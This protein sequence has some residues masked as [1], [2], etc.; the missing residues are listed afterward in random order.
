MHACTTY[1]NRYIIYR[2]ACTY[3]NAYV[4]ERERERHQ[5]Q[6][7]ARR[8]AQREGEGREGD[9]INIIL[10][11]AT[12]HYTTLSYTILYYTIH[13]YIYIYIHNVYTYIYIYIDARRAPRRG[14]LE[15]GGRASAWVIIM[16]MIIRIIDYD[17][18]NN[19]SNNNINNNN[20]NNNNNNGGRASASAG[21]GRARRRS[22]RA[23][24]RECFKTKK[25]KCLN[26]IF[27]LRMSKRQKTNM[28]RKTS[29]KTL[30]YVFRETTAN[31]F[32]M[33]HVYMWRS[34]KSQ[35]SGRGARWLCEN[36]QRLRQNVC[37]QTNNSECLDVWA[38]GPL[39]RGFVGFEMLW[40]QTD[41][42]TGQL[43]QLFVPKTAERKKAV[44]RNGSA[45]MC[46][47]FGGITCLTPLA[48][49]GLVCF[50]RF[51]SCQGSQ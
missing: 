32:D 38:T 35:S 16:I 9:N 3:F 34:S 8:R 11:Y 44:R 20:S 4:C 12:L 41:Q 18:N 37:I 40:D 29:A 36:V 46:C 21:R 28:F 23:A 45:E 26:H 14:P 51:S 33:I 24:G 50:V 13:I 15:F 1:V 27:D 17:N 5:M 49:Y 47:M 48:W 19:N 2:H 39:R 7:D 25:G 43:L 22:P 30:W 10:H 6:T 31:I 42:T